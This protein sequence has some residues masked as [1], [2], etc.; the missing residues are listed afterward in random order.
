MIAQGI[1]SCSVGVISLA[2]IG[3]LNLIFLSKQRSDFPLFGKAISWLYI[4]TGFL[5]LTS[6]VLNILAGLRTRRFQNR[7]LAIV[8]LVTNAVYMFSFFSLPCLPSALALMIF[9]LIVMLNQDVRR[10]FAGTSMGSG[11]PEVLA[12]AI[13]ALPA[14]RPDWF[15]RNW[16]WFVP[17]VVLLPVLALGGCGGCLFFGLQFAFKSSDAYKNAVARVQADPVVTAAL[18]SPVEPGLFTYSGNISDAGPIGHAE[19]V[20]P[21]SGPKGSGTVYLVADK[22]GGK[23]EFK[24]LEVTLDGTETPINLLDK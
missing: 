23:W 14:E 8:A 13:T 11:T 5:I 3:P 4:V 18:G 20:F 21:I 1:L 10:A 12:P 19:V 24:V 2:V 6:G 22:S 15:G 17:S 16:K 7:L 9:G